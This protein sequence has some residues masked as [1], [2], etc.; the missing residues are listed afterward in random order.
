[1]T[2]R[3]VGESRARAV[4]SSPGPRPGPPTIR[5]VAAAAGV[6]RATASRV[7]N[8]GELVSDRARAAVEAAIAAL[9]FTPNPVARNLARG[10]TGSVALVV[11]EPNA[12]VLTDPFFAETIVGLSESLEE[13]DL[14]LVLL[15][16][17]SGG[18]TE[19]IVRYLAGGHVDGA[20]IASHHRDDGLNSTA[21]ALGLPCVFIGRP[22]GVPR[23]HYVDMDNVGGARLA[24][25]HLIARGRRR[26]GTIAGPADM[27]AG[28]DR[29]EGWR[30]AMTA[31][32]LPTDAVAIGDFTR[33]G[34]REAAERLLAAHPDLDAIFAASDLMAAGAMSLLATRRLRVPEDVAMFG[35]D[36]LGFAETTDPPLST[37]AQ[38]VARIAA[39]AGRM[40][41]ALLSGEDADPPPRLFPPTVVVRASA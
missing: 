32:G 5:Q 40:L 36:D 6:S 34:G 14:Q 8:G 16:A 21:V 35:F 12:R 19:K 4:R 22:L 1:M 41:L 7:I 37:I 13:S 25:E 24:T 33:P 18:R 9:G 20:V 30:A 11:P 26:I 39:E 15:I 3:E 28:I 31:A 23:A 29:L 10:R 27:T 2:T 38:P 17:R